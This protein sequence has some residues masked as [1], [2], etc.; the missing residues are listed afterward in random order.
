MRSLSIRERQ[1]GTDHPN[2][3]AS[4]FNLAALYQ[5]K[6]T[7]RHPEALQSIQRTIQIYERKLGTEHPNT[8]A[9]L[10]WLQAIREAS[11]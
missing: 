4:L 1:L 3:A 7:Q 8:Q 10:S 5:N 6:N 11:L 2:V 9:A